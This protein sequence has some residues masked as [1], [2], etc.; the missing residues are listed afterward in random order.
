MDFLKKD[1]MEEK[2]QLQNFCFVFDFSIHQI[3]DFPLPS[4]CFSSVSKSIF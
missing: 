4:L 1:L 3:I 2:I